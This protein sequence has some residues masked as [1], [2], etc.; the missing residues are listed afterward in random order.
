MKMTDKELLKEI[1][2]R[3]AEADDY[4]TCTDGSYE[5]LQMYITPIKNELRDKG[6]KQYAILDDGRCIPVDEK[7][8]RNKRNQV[9]TEDL[10]TPTGYF[11][12]FV[13]KK[14]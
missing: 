7:F 9:Y 6:Y 2:K 11:K 13:W 12:E 10:Y 8:Y 4:R 3:E 1:K 5:Q 14:D